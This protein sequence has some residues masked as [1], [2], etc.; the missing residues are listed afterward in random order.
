MRPRVLVLQESVYDTVFEPYG[1]CVNDCFF[2]NTS[3]VQLCTEVLDNTVSPSPD[4]TL[5]TLNLKEGYWRSSNSS[6]DILECYE[7][8]ACV[9]GVGDY[10][11]TGYTGPCES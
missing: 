1:K 8:R 7:P 6:K 3:D 10:C 4:G 11:E 2:D 9:G 5:A